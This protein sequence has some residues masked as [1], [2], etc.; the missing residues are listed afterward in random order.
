MSRGQEAYY[1]MEPR[2]GIGDYRPLGRT[3]WDDIDRKASELLGRECVGVPSVRVGMCWTLEHLGYSRHSDHVLVPKFM[4]RCILNSLN[5]YAM[6]VEGLT[7]ETRAVIAVHQYG[8]RQRL[9][10]IEEECASRGIPYM[11]DSPYGLESREELGPGSLAKFIGLGKILPVLKGAL[12]ISQDRSL[13]AFIKYKRQGSSL[14]SWAVLGAMA[15]LRRRRKVGSYSA[16]ADTAYEMYVECK[17]DN[18]WLRGNVLRALERLD[19]LGSETRRR[20]S[21]IEDRIG[22]RVLIPDA[23]HVGYVVPYFPEDGASQ[24][25]EV[26]RTY[27]FDPALYHIDVDRNMFCPRYEMGHLIPLNPRIPYRQFEGLVRDL[28]ALTPM[29]ASPIRSAL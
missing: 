9:E 11:E 18:M 26:F 2:V 16:L 20:L 19:S 14:W 27:G 7:S 21:N 6:P 8:L 3:T 1:P 24:S 13:L 29:R 25:R 4:G 5:R 10:L 15:I 28:A 17:G 12:T 23:R 22:D